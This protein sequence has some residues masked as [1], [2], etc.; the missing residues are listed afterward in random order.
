MQLIGGLSR[1]SLEYQSFARYRTPCVT[2][3]LV[4]SRC[5]CAA[6]H[7]AKS[8]GKSHIPKWY[9][10]WSIASIFIKTF[11]V[12]ISDSDVKFHLFREAK[13]NLKIMKRRL[14][15]KF[16]WGKPLTK[17][18]IGKNMS[19]TV[20]KHRQRYLKWLHAHIQSMMVDTA[21]FDCLNTFCINIYCMTEFIGSGF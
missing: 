7:V 17:D 14:M 11:F 19:K 13:K 16:W 18:V 10:V 20:T 8:M 21:G 5:V 3:T 9:G 4:F 12:I 2:C 6:G 1:P 15:C